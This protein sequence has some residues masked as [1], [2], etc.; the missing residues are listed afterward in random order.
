MSSSDVSLSEV[1]STGLTTFSESLTSMVAQIKTM[2]TELRTLQKNYNKLQREHERSLKRRYRG[3]TRPSGIAMPTRISKELA[4]LLDLD[5]LKETYKRNEINKMMSNYF[6][7]NN[8]RTDPK[9]QRKI[10]PNDA[11]RSLFNLDD[12][13]DHFTYLQLQTHMKPHF[14]PVTTT[15]A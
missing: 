2:Q 10:Y 12:N 9:D 5:P 4:N 3:N 7:N 8:L 11:L 13:F 14:L 6:V 1:V 15:S